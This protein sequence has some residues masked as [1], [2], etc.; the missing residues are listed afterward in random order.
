MGKRSIRKRCITLKDTAN[1]PDFLIA[2]Y[3]MDMAGL[4]EKFSSMIGMQMDIR[5]NLKPI[6]RRLITLKKHIEQIRKSVYSILRQEQWER[7]PRRTQEMDL[8]T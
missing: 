3:I 4:D 5:D 2:D 7:Q 1:M 8:Q 6:D